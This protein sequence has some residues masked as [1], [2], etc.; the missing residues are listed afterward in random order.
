MRL[1]DPGE[2]VWAWVPYEEDPKQGK[3][4]PVVVIG[5]AGRM[6]LVVPLSSQDRSGPRDAR[7][8]IEVGSGPWDRTGRSSFANT[9]RILQC[10]PRGVRREGGALPRDRF[11]R[12]V[13]RVRT[14]HPQEFG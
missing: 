13:E 14:L 7:A 1:P 6:L 2:V 8:W 4:R 12:V 11:E 9:A 3:D 5:R 10:G